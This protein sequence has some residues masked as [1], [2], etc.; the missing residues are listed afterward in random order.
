MAPAQRRSI[1][2]ELGKSLLGRCSGD[3]HW[4]KKATEAASL[5]LTARTSPKS[6]SAADGLSDVVHDSNCP[7]FDTYRKNIITIGVVIFIV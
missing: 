6:S 2:A 1:K 4:N 7:I 5:P 3:F